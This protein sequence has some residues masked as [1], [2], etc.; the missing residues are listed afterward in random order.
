M[1]TAF[2]LKETTAAVVGFITILIAVILLAALVGRMTRGLFRLVGL[3]VFDNILGVALSGLKM[4]L[5]V[6]I[7]LM[8]ADFLDAK[9]TVIT[10]EIKKSSPMY[11]AATGVAAFVF[12]YVDTITG[13]VWERGRKTD[14]PRHREGREI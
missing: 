10:R 5:V 3:G 12:P 4:L 8:L 6:G 14:E 11:K 7:V 13:K 1:G 9:E 2:G